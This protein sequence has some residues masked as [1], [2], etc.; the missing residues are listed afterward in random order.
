MPGTRIMSPK[1]GE[2]HLGPLRERDRVVLAAHR[3][4]ADG[5]AWPVDELDVVGEQVLDAVL[6]DGVGVAAADLH[7]LVGAA[8]V[9]KLGDL[10]RQ[11]LGELRVAVL[12]DEPHWVGPVTRSSATPAWQSST[13]PTR[14]VLDQ[15]D[16][17]LLEGAVLLDHRRRAHHLDHPRLHGDVA[18]G[19]ARLG[20]LSRSRWS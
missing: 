17:H 1:V 10:R 18:A 4:H 15:V 20:V 11:P 6:V 2:D 16:R 14:D 9:D 12:V 19:D 8:L 3:D 7:Q 13:S 5:A